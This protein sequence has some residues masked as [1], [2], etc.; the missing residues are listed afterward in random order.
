MGEPVRLMVDL[1]NEAAMLALFIHV[2]GR[3]LMVVS[4]AGDGFILP[5]DEAVAQ[6]RAGRQVLNLRPGA[7]AR[8]CRPVSG[9]HVAVVG[10]NR[11]MLIFSRAELP[12]MGR[13]KGVRLQRYKDGGLSDALT[14]DLNDV[15]TWKDPAGR[16]STV[17]D[18][19]EWMGA[20]ASAGR[21]A[22]RGFPRDLRFD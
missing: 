13:G 7:R 14:F 2:P 12:E 1:P 16:T 4:E 20:R 8:V 9:D 11:K 17:N 6:T 18:L 21:M 15:L 5:E 22:P 19:A 3:R 10:E